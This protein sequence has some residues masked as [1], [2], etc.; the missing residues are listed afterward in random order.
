MVGGRW[1]QGPFDKPI[2]IFSGLLAGAEG[3]V[4]LDAGRRAQLGVDL[5]QMRADRAVGDVAALADLAVGQAVVVQRRRGGDLRC[6]L[7]ASLQGPA[8][9]GLPA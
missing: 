3:A 8:S 1:N 2:L 4:Q 6:G 7:L 5:G 9:A